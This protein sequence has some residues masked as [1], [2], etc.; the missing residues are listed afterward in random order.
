M[1]I[2]ARPVRLE[3][4]RRSKYRAIPTVLDGH[5]FD[6]RLEARYY[7]TLQ[8][9]QRIGAVLEIRRQPNYLLEVNGVWVGRYVADYEVVRAD[10]EIQVVDCKG[11]RTQ[12]YKLKRR[13]FEALYPFRIVE[14]TR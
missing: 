12:T 14:I 4:A 10:G 1:K 3:T 8:L 7:A 5:R 2:T 9:E 11:F 6:S 13:L